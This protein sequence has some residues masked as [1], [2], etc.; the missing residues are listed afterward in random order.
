MTRRGE[1]RDQG[2][3]AG[4]AVIERP[5]FDALLA[6]LRHRGYTVVGPTVRDRAIVYDEVASSA[7]L[8]IG[9]S[10]EQDGGHYRLR[11]RDDD[12]LFGYAVGPHSWKRYQLPPAVRLFR[13][14]LGDDGSLTELVEPPPE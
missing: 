1:R 2:P 8:P 10:D 4:A 13:A 12:A 3:R 11:R 5:D 14:R 6:A 7:D 9:W